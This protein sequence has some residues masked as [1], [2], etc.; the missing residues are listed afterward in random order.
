MA[1]DYRQDCKNAL[2]TVDRDRQVKKTF[3][4]P[5]LRKC[6]FQGVPGVPGVPTAQTFS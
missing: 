6:V 4:Q 2:M 5:K 1:R 3:F